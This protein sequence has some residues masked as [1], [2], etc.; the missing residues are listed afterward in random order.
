MYVNFVKVYQKGEDGDAII[1]PKNEE[2]SLPQ[3]PVPMLANPKGDVIYD[4][5][6]KLR[7]SDCK[8][9]D[10]HIFIIKKNNSSEKIIMR[11]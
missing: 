3:I 8:K 1:C 9:S 4:V 2:T 11:K 7:S 6:G 5:N 10:N